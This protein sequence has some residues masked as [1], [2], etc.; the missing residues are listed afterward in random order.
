ML[1]F[2]RA[3]CGAKRSKMERKF[4]AEAKMKFE[5][6]ADDAKNDWAKICMQNYETGALNAVFNSIKIVPTQRVMQ[7]TR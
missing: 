5:I 6:R 7:S 1:V 2:G 3:N 4:C